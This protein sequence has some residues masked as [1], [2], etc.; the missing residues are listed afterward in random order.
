MGSFAE[1]DKVRLVKFPHTP[2]GRVTQV[3]A[4]GIV[5]RWSGG[6]DSPLTH[7]LA[8]NILEKL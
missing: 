7:L 1:G 5:V 2:P 8:K 4:K 6:N 3:D